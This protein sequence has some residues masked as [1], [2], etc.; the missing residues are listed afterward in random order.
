MHIRRAFYLRKENKK[1]TRD[2][3][4]TF[5]QII[6]YSGVEKQSMIAME[7]LAELIKA[8]SK[9]NRNVDFDKSFAN[10]VEEIADV[11]IMIE[12]LKMMY[13]I[14]NEAVEKVINFKTERL[15]KLLKELKAV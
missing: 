2:Q 1:M 5:K 15:K 3:R 4:E 13:H 8:I 11:E 14:N 6:L 10:V 7:E 9:L 12:Q